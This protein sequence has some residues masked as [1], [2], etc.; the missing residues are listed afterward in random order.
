MAVW[1][2]ISIFF[3]L[4]IF[5]AFIVLNVITTNKSKNMSQKSR[6]Y[7][8]SSKFDPATGEATPFVNLNGEP[9]IQCPAGTK[10]NI[11]GAMYNVFDPYGE[12]TG[13]SP[14]DASGVSPELAYLCVPGIQSKHTCQNAGDCPNSRE[15]DP[16]S[17]FSCVQNHCELKPSAPNTPCLKGFSQTTINGN[18]YCIDADICGANIDKA[19]QRG[20]G[21]PNPYCSPSNTVSKCA[22]RD[23]SATVASL[24]DGKSDCK[25]LSIKDLDAHIPCPGIPAVDKKC[26]SG[27]TSNGKPIWDV[28]SEGKRAGYCGL[29]YIPGYSGGVPQGSSSDKPDP[30]NT[31]LGYTVHGI[32]TCIPA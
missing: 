11:V 32:Y 14:S 27:Y 28:N 30:A 8:F 22:I 31:N 25:N 18:V 24:C 13:S 5:I 10:I 3:L 19:S 9:Q 4:L 17:Q 7:T 23:A 15:G 26:I 20:T 29:P 6:L 21:V 1:G 16:N 12:C 2:I